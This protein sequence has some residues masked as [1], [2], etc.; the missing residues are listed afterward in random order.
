MKETSKGGMGPFQ[1]HHLIYG[2]TCDQT[3]DLLEVWLMG[4][5]YNCQLWQMVLSCSVNKM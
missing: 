3:F 1:E 4:V 2:H 5:I